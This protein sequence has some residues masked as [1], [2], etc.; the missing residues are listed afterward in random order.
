MDDLPSLSFPTPWHGGLSGKKSSSSRIRVQYK[1]LPDTV[2]G[3]M[4]EIPLMSGE[5]GGTD[6][7]GAEWKSDDEGE[8]VIF[9]QL[10]GRQR[11]QRRIRSRSTLFNLICD[12]GW[13]LMLRKLDI[14]IHIHM[15]RLPS[16]VPISHSQ[17]SALLTRLSITNGLLA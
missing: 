12:G 1:A 7:E 2:V 4:D 9:D 10:G 15:P 13:Q 16:L 17:I 6:D 5:D 14:K 3:D 11:W 8:D